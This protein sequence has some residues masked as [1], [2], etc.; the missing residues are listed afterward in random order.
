M[1]ASGYALAC[2][3]LVYIIVAFLSIY[4]YG[5]SIS[6]NIMDNVSKHEGEWTAILLGVV[7]LV[8]LGCHIPF[9][10]FSG[11]QALFH[12]VNELG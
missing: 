7:F 10:F 2:S 12:L 1:K 4:M 11:K 9:I 3:M 5:S 6:A 8:V